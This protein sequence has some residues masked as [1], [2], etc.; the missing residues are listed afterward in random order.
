[1]DR[2]P[3][4]FRENIYRSYRRMRFLV[5]RGTLFTLPGQNVDMAGTMTMF[6]KFTFRIIMLNSLVIFLMSYFVVYFMTLLVTA[7][8]ASAFEINTV[9][10]YYNID[11]L[12]R[13]DEWTSDAVSAVFASGPLFSVFFAI[14]LFILYFN[15]ASETGLLRLAVLWAFCHLVINFFGSMLVGSILNEGFGYVIMY[16]FVMDTG[17]M[18]ITLFAFICLFLIGLFTTRLFLFSANSYFN[19][20]NRYNRMKFVLSQFLVPFLLGNI[21]IFLFKLPEIRLFDILLNASTLLIILPVIFR[22]VTIQDMF[23]DEDPRK[24]KLAGYF[25][26]V[27]VLVM[28][29]FRVGLTIGLRI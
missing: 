10:F 28:I 20:L 19:V 15:V 12:I 22:S 23:F 14:L 18:I 17:K 8:S 3:L 29:T 24:V 25:I 26:L 5:R 13:G 9:I 21:I 7:I 11:Y 1:M 6:P 4:T 2:S 16:M 27:T